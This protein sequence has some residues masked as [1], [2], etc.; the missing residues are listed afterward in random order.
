VI[1]P[2][3]ATLMLLAALVQPALAYT[4]GQWVDNMWIDEGESIV[5]LAPDAGKTVELNGWTRRGRS[6][7]YRVV[8]KAGDKL[9]IEVYSKSAYL[10][11]AVFDFATPDDEAIF[12]S[13]P[14]NRQTI[15]TIKSDTE[16]LIR[17]ILILGQ[18]RRG[19]GVKYHLRLER[20]ALEQAD[21][22]N[23]PDAEGAQQQ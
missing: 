13:E 23:K 4:P 3:A 16:L 12:F 9:R 19:L 6:N 2:L 17:P 18:P 20:Q 1:K 7:V 11:L 22:G 21:Q 5:E 10:M 14:D 8:V 15:L